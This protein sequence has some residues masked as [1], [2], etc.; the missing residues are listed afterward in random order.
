MS[1]FVVFVLNKLVLND[2]KKALNIQFSAF[3]ILA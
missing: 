3:L 2:R 1:G